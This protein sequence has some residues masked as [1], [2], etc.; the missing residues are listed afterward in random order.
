MATLGDLVNNAQ[1]D[2]NTVHSYLPLYQRL[3][4]GKRETARNILEVGVCNG[5]S[6]KLWNDFFVNAD[7]YGIDVMHESEMWEGI[8]NQPRIHLCTS[9]DGYNQ[10][11]INNRFVK[12]NI[13]FDFILDDGWH[14]LDSQR[15]F[16]RAYLPLLA[17]NGILIVEDIS[18]WDWI[19]ILKNEVPEELKKYVRAY[20]LRPLKGRY[21]DI[22]FTIDRANTW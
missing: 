20:D 16:I 3:L 13:K 5:G 21:D 1:T 9:T 15:M 12:N 8:K 10:D 11:F 19:E 22:V 17:D 2:K 4:V 14:T 18:S 7:I 6:V